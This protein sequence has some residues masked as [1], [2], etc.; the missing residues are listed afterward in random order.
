MSRGVSWHTRRGEALFDAQT[1]LQG[2][3][4]LAQRCHFGRHVRRRAK[5][6]RRFERSRSPSKRR[7]RYHVVRC[8][9]SH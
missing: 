7:S 2:L 4:L 6:H 9:I 3:R 5:W 8:R 1:H